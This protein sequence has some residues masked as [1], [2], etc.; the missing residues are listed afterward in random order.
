MA[1]EWQAAQLQEEAGGGIEAEFSKDD[2]VKP[3]ETSPHTVATT[4]RFDPDIITSLM[5]Q[6]EFLEECTPGKPLGMA[7]MKY[8]HPVDERGANR[9]ALLATRAVIDSITTV[10]KDLSM[11]P[12]EKG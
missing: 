10:L 12:A 11:V 5:M 8:T 2:G 7:P 9:K 6:P 3:E 4:D 1:E